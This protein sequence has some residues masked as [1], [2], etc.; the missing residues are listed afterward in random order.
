MSTP[1]ASLEKELRSPATGQ[2]KWKVDDGATVRP[3]KVLAKIL[4]AQ[5]NKV[6]VTFLCESAASG[7]ITRK[8]QDGQVAQGDLLAVI[9]CQP[10]PVTS[11][12]PGLA[13]AATPSDKSHAAAPAPV[14]TEGNEAAESPV[15]PVTLRGSDSSS[16][17]HAP[18]NTVTPARLA[19]LAQHRD[20]IAPLVKQRDALLEE[21]TVLQG[22][23]T[24][25]ERE[26]REALQKQLDAELIAVRARIAD[27]LVK[28]QQHLAKL[29]EQ[30]G[31]ALKAFEERHQKLLKATEQMEAELANTRLARIAAMEKELADEAGVRREAF[32]KQLETE[33]R[34]FDDVLNA[35]MTAFTETKSKKEKE[36]DDLV[37]KIEEDSRKLQL[38]ENALLAQQADVD[39]TRD[40]LPKTIDARVREANEEANRQLKLKDKTIQDLR[41]RC[42]QLEK[43]QEAHDE[44]RRRLDN[45]SPEQ[46]LEKLRQQKANIKRLEDELGE[47]PP[48]E[49]KDRLAAIEREQQKWAEDRAKLTK[50][51]ARLQAAE[52]SWLLSVGALEQQKTLKEQLERTNADLVKVL[53]ARRRSVDDELTKLQADAERLKSLYEQPQELAARIG[54]ITQPTLPRQAARD[55]RIEED[56]WLAQIQADCEKSGLVFPKRLLVALHTALKTAEWSPLTVL[57]GVSGTGKSELPRLY[58]RFGGL[59]FLPLAV[60]PNWDSPQSIFGFFNS[61]DNRFNATPL[62]Q[63]LTQSQR[64]SE[65]GDGLS[66]QV[67][68]VLLD[69]MNLAHVEL[70]FSDLLSKLELRRGEAHAPE[71]E[72]DLGAGLHKHRVPLGCNVL[73]CGTMNEDETTKALSDKV[74]DR[75][76]LLVFPRPTVLN[77]RQKAQLA[78]ARP[79]LPLSTWDSWIVHESR[80]SAEQV[81]PFK[82]LL[83]KMN[84]YLEQVGRALGHRV[85]QSV[86]YYMA[87]HP[88]VTAAQ[89]ASDDPALAKAMSRAFEDQLVQKVMPKLRGIETSGKART[90]CLDPIRGLL[91]QS[92]LRVNLARDFELACSMGYGSFQWKSAK[93]LEVEQ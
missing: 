70:Y 16:D 83:E 65:D 78:E 63:L 38:R 86:E 56:S 59:N 88:E 18:D 23:L 91:A 77:R 13:D 33:R 27:E 2:I 28:H 35:E 14:A 89:K 49:L 54:V 7:V 45:Q 57:A 46:I 43:E 92:S 62:L 25:V 10:G 51:L 87:N 67:S 58:A 20:A 72:I 55:G 68:L 5:G 11:S 36:W 24:S 15:T 34:E 80:F 75:G 76:N 81:G 53:D 52:H 64:A 1:A 61:V 12:P 29:T 79:M 71:I 82:E 31:T 26:R 60:Q 48:V 30:T 22:K 39:D 85:W 90:A 4:P 9:S 17:G 3:G 66:D 69:E 47:R 19:A 37:K 74:L 93:Y 8:A 6:T 40:R 44:M 41:Q 84:L 50:E 32:R 42:E 73:W 21:I